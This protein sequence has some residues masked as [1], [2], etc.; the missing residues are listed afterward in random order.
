MKRLMIVAM[1]ASL[2]AMPAMAQTQ[3]TQPPPSID[4][5]GLSP[6]QIAQV[7]ADV[8]AQRA[9]T[10]VAKA[11]A[12]NEWVNI[13]TG[14]GSGLAA[15]ARETGQVVNEFANT[16]VGKLTIAVILFKVMGGDLIQLIIGLIFFAAAI[17]GWIA[18][19]RRVFA[20]RTVTIVDPTTKIK[21][22]TRDPGNFD[23]QKQGAMLIMFLAGL[24]IAGIGS[25]IS[26]A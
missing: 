4:V 22:V 20:V 24:V 2:L 19:F 1:A 10:P 26:L 14:I 17:S 18:C 13:G 3:P 25:W 11:Q 15:A 23:S 16:P 9:S 5:S 6:E 8:A 12:V 21:T 7:N